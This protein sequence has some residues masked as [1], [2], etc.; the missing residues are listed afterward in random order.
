MPVQK[1]SGNLLNA[2]RIYIYIYMIEKQKIK[3][4]FLIFLFLNDIS[5]LCISLFV[6]IYICYKLY[7]EL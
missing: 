2:P 5:F 7:I 1:K 6:Y 4:F 3:K